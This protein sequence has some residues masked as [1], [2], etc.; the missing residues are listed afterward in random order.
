MP[1]ITTVANVDVALDFWIGG[2]RVPSSALFEVI[3]RRRP[4]GG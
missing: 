2:T 4:T 1:I 3:E